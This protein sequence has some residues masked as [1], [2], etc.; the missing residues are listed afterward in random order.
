M[1][2]R[3]PGRNDDLPIGRFLPFPPGQGNVLVPTA[4]RRAAALGCTLY[5]ASKPIPIALQTVLWSV[6]RVGGQRLLP[7]QRVTWDPPVSVPTMRRLWAAWTTVAGDHLDGL[8]V[9]NRPQSSR[10]GIA[11]LLSSRRRSTLVRL[12]RD[13]NQLTQEISIS[14]AA[15]RLS[16]RSFR[17]P[18][19]L[20][21]GSVDD[22]HWSAFELMTSRPHRPARTASAALT[23]EVSALVESVVTRRLDTPRHWTGS[24]GD[25]T[26][27]NLRKAGR[28]SN[29]PWLIDWEDA[30]WAPPGLDQ[31]YF[32]A[33]SSAIFP[34]R[35][36]DPAP[37]RR[38]AEAAAQAA[39]AIRARP[40]DDPDLTAAMLA[41]L[42]SIR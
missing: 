13:P 42:D 32:A 28:S 15:E 41:T 23:E 5:T 9:Y 34:R 26:P 36:V 35:R 30:E 14:Q 38:Y 12:R 33:S 37:L 24:H 3:T 8:A 27:W 4:P 19:V 31:V 25:L 20:D 16:T 17:V 2:S 7:G 18:R 29:P 11:V 40:D 39:S 21:V 22:W 1:P 10:P 6:L